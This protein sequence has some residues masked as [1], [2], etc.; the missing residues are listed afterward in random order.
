M[1]STIVVGLDGGS[2]RL[3]HQ[4]MEEGNCPTLQSLR[5]EG[6]WAPLR[7]SL[8]P[9]TCPAWRCYSTGV[10]PG[11]HG[12]F[13]WEQVDRERGDFSIPTST[14]FDAP[15]VWDYLGAKGFRSA[16]VNMPTTFPPEPLDGYMVSGGGGVDGKEYTYPP[17]LQ[18][19]IESRFD[20]RAFIEA[21]TAEI[22]EDP[23]LVDEVLELVDARFRVA[24]YIRDEYD[25]DFLHVTVFYTNVL[26]HFFWDGEATRRIWEH[27]DEILS[28]FLRS[29][30]NVIIISDHGTNQI[31]QTFNVNTWL[32]KEGY[33][34]TTETVSDRLH[35]VNVTRDRLARLASNFGLK[36]TAKLLLPRRLIDRLPRADG[37]ITGAGKADKIDWEA[38]TAMASGQGP[39]Y[40]LA[41]NRERSHQIREELKE[42]LENVE[43]PDGHPVART[44]HRGSEV[45]TGPYVDDGP[46]LVVDQADHVYIS[47]AIGLDDM[48]EL[49]NDWIA[50]NH[51]NGIFIANGPDIANGGELPDYPDIYD[52]APTILHLFG[53]AVPTN[54]DGRVLT[55]IF[56]P[57]SAPGSR[58]VTYIDSTLAND[59]QPRKDPDD[60]QIRDRLK[61]LGYL[62]E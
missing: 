7:S 59:Q 48:F 54:L 8:P 37:A 43:T 5:D 53:L 56:R 23:S 14:S 13:W 6:R 25:P 21:S 38:S 20:Y 47:G 19:E 17:E 49:P 27:V 31:E 29:E 40:V 42:S 58:E 33:L 61:D 30:D 51:R 26:H 35:E 2:F 16:I 1:S 55:E 50:E 18:E 41:D 3:L 52:I 60:G 44:V 4:W 34:V 36:N 24:E 9:V 10:N 15:D 32:E 45:Y 22:G 11:K 12:V 62:S 39:I 28:R 46:D 57:G